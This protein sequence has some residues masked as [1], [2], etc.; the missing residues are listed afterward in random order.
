MEP[1]TRTLLLV[2]LGAALALGVGC[3]VLVH[4]AYEFVVYKPPREEKPHLYATPQ[5]LELEP[6]EPPAGTSLS[7]L[8]YAVDTPWTEV[9]DTREGDGFAGFY[10][11]SGHYVSAHLTDDESTPLGLLRAQDEDSRR[12]LENMLGKEATQSNH[13]YYKAVFSATPDDYS[14]SSPFQ[15]L[16]GLRLLLTMKDALAETAASGLYS[17]ETQHMRG[18]QLGHPAKDQAV[19]IFAFDSSDRYLTLYITAQEGTGGHVTQDQIN[20][21]I[22][23]IRPAEEPRE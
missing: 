16:M 23:S 18:F 3:F 6:C 5:L 12:N 14:I 10:F 17:F 1:H 22:Q 19:T 13:G 11:R 15:R 7:F 21:I 2:L 9:V 4:K 8:G 20:C